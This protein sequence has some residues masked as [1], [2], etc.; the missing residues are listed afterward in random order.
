MVVLLVVCGLG[1]RA[2]VA[3][4]RADAGATA[5]ADVPENAS[6]ESAIVDTVVREEPPLAIATVI[7]AFDSQHIGTIERRWDGI[8]GE[9]QVVAF[10]P[11]LG[12]GEEYAVWA[13]RDGLADVARLGTLSLRADGGWSGTFFF[14]PPG[15]APIVSFSTLVLLRVPVNATI[16]E[17]VTMA[18]A[19]F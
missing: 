4:F 1:F 16:P 6:G 5:G 3:K 13:L 8:G 11:A 14:A 10:L 15:G 9:F 2:A 17:G 18:R 19:V 12:P 7:S